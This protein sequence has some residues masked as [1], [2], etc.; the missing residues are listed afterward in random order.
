MFDKLTRFK[1]ELL[2][3]ISII[4]KPLGVLYDVP[5]IIESFNFKPY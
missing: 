3:G 4:T 5:V 2:L 1:I